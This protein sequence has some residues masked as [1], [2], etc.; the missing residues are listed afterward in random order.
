MQFLVDLCIH[1]FFILNKKKI[2]ISSSVYFG[3]TPYSKILDLYYGINLLFDTI[4]LLKSH[5]PVIKKTAI[6]WYL[7][8]LF[9]HSQVTIDNAKQAF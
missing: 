5:K 9:F 3:S 4:L 2:M 1:S 8:F 7:R 6:A